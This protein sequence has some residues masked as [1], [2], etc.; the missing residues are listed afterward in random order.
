[1]LDEDDKDKQPVSAVID[2]QT[3]NTMVIEPVGKELLTAAEVAEVESLE[4]EIS[5]LTLKDQ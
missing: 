5:H 3:L 2:E 4:I 1:M